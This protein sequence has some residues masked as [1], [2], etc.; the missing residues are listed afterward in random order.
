MKVLLIDPPIQVWE[1]M[2]DCCAPPLGL[3]YIAAVLERNDIPVEL[4]HCNGM[5]ISWKDLPRLIRK[6]SPDILGTGAMTPMFSGAVKLVTMAKEI[7]PQIKTVVGGSHVTFTYEDTLRQIPEIDIVVRGEGEET[8]V[9]LVK[10]L[11]TRSDLKNVK[12]IAYRNNGNITVTE[13]RPPVDVNSL[14][15]PAYHLLPMEKYHFEFLE[16]FSTML[17]SRG[18]P[19][20]CTFCSEWGFWGR[21]WRARN[22]ESVGEELEIVTRKYKRKSVWFGDDCFNANYNH[23]KGICEQIEERDLDVQWFYQGRADFLIEYRD[24][25]PLM[26]KTGNVMTQIGVEASTNEGLTSLNKKVS[27]EQMKEA[28]HLMKKYDIVSQGLIIIGTPEDTKESILHKIAY[29][30][31]LKVDFPIF[32]MFTPFPGSIVYE[33]AKEENLIEDFDFDHFDMAY[34]VMPTDKMRRDELFRWYGE[35]HREYYSDPLQILTGLLSRN[36]FKRAIWRH[37]FRYGLKQAIRMY[38]G[39][40]KYRL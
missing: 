5:N 33:K 40:G 7:D 3:A 13:N 29:M 15:L 4:I 2:G 14:P 9:D 1:L 25:L 11:E 26:Q 28:V 6:S 36:R 34:V 16:E 38:R 24:L 8:I 39:K 18:C 19:F 37:M 35:C 23:I 17:T 30:K 22:P 32:T 21:P 12:G 20:S 27:V 10:C 31:S